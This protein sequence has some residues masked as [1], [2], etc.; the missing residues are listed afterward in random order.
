MADALRSMTGFGA[1]EG[2]LSARLSASVRL[3]SV[4]G[5]FLEPSVRTQPRFDTAALEAAL[6][7]VLAERM[8]RGRVQVLVL[9]QVLQAGGTGLAFHW[10][11]AEALLAEL[12]HAPAGLDLA[13]V[14]LRDLL[15]LPGFAEGLGEVALDEAEQQALLAL[16]AAA[17][18]ALVAV[19]EQEAAALLPQV[20]GEVAILDGFADWL[21]GINGQVQQVLM[22]RLRERLATLLE[23]VTLPEDRL[24][25]EAALGADRADV[26][27]EIQRL[28]AHLDH[29]RRLLA[30]GG[31]VGKKLDFLIQELLREINTAGSKCRE[32]GM[33]ERVVEAKAAVEKLREQAA[34]FE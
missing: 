12:D 15:S 33:G 29:L 25:T 1:A 20:E 31:P 28:R 17:R 32:A 9:L 8:S 11:V 16:V 10:E 13:P 21:D 30:G 14:S 34:N 22:A 23:G 27:E 24:L 19:R 2:A 18:D 4:N 3:T 5:R 6:R 26:S 7:S